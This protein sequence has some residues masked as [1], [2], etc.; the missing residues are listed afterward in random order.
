VQMKE[1]NEWKAIFRMSRG[2]FKL[3]VMFFGL[4]NSPSTF[5]TMMNEIF[6]DLVMEGVVC[7]YLDDILIYTKTMEEHCHI[8]CLVLE[9]LHKH[10][11]FLQH[12]KYE[13][14]CTQI[15]YLGLVVAHRSIAMDPIKVAGVAEWPVPKTKKELQ[16]F[17]GFTNFYCRF[18]EGFLHHAKPLFDLTKKDVPWAWNNNQQKAFN[19]LK[20]CITSSLVL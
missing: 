16:S 4:T 8:T 6:Q 5:Q 7:V 19:E 17:L 10:K 1:G 15:E 9:R 3:L 12:D 11:L 13:F 2:L 18:I 14:K 20:N